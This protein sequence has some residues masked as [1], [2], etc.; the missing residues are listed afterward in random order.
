MTV[1]GAPP[2]GLWICFASWCCDEYLEVIAVREGSERL[3]DNILDD[4]PST[5]D[6]GRRFTTSSSPT[7]IS[8]AWVRPL[9]RLQDGLKT[10]QTRRA[11]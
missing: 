7:D 8:T 1:L 3:H 5:L 9:G 6:A 11:H 10:P 4:T 2:P